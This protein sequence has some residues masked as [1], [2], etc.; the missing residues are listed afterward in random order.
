MLTVADTFTNEEL[1]EISG[2]IPP[3]VVAAIVLAEGA[4]IGMWA[5]LIVEK[6]TGTLKGLTKPLM[7]K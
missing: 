5:A 7:P 6:G 1:D 2:G 4:V 3:A